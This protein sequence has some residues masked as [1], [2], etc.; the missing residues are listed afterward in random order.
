MKT[1]GTLT[2]TTE[3]IQRNKQMPEGMQTSKN[4]IDKYASAGLSRH[5]P[6]V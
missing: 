6:S 5:L 3:A 4:L 1:C 2:K